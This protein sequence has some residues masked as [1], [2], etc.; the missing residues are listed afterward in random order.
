MGSFFQTEIHFAVNNSNFFPHIFFVLELIRASL[1]TDG[2]REM[3]K[4]AKKAKKAPA[5]KAAK[6]AAKKKR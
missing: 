4:A 5:K 3:A 6:K 2:E 1:E